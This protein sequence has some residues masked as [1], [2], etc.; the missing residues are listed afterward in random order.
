VLSD[1]KIQAVPNKNILFRCGEER[2]A[3]NIIKNCGPHR[4]EAPDVS[5]LEA[6]LADP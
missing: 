4:A 1:A 2:R 5:P 6:A 3:R